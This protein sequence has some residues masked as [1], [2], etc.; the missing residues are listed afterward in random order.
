LNELTGKGNF[1]GGVG[2]LLRLCGTGGEERREWWRSG[3]GGATRRKKK[4]ENE[5]LVSTSGGQRGQGSNGPTA[6]RAGGAGVADAWDLAGGGR[7]RD[8][9]GMG[10]VG[11]PGKKRS[12]PSSD[13]QESLC[14][15]QLNFKLV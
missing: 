4:H 6:E 1:G 9:R 7:G 15:N 11:R 2:A 8:E 3:A 14:F 13:E 5:G 12:G 10:R